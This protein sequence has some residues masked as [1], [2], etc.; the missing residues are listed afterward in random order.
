MT[1]TADLLEQTP[2]LGEDVKDP[3]DCFTE[4]PSPVALCPSLSPAW[5]GREDQQ[6]LD[7]GS[8]LH[9]ILARLPPLPPPF[10]RALGAPP[11]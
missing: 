7:A 11:L 2:D 6:L 10:I 5:R 9:P 3:E 4:G 1:I 8:I